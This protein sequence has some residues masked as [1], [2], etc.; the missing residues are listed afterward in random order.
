MMASLS[1]ASY[2]HDETQILDWT[3][4]ACKDSKVSMKPGGIKTV[5]DSRELNATRVLV[6]KLKD[7]S[8]CLLAFRGSATVESWIRDFSIL[9]KSVQEDFEGC[10][11]HRFHGCRVH[12]G[13]LKIWKNVK[14]GVLKALDDV[15]CTPYSGENHLY[16]TGH[17]LGAA[18]AN[19]AAF[20]L[21][22]SGFQIAK[23][24]TFESP[25]IGNKAFADAFD[26][27]FSSRIPVFRITHNADIIVHAPPRLMSYHHVGQEAWY[28]KDGDYRVCKHSEDS[29]CANQFSR[30]F[31][32]PS[33][34]FDHCDSPL[35][36]SGHICDPVG[37]HPQPTRPTSQ[38][39]AIVV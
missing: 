34:I 16:M 1:S 31:P 13:F 11:R 5:V 39:H 29:S 20:D 14:A 6:G 18:L 4:Q 33:D 10:E 32:H 37:C 25:R 12:S 17:S 30:H 28:D 38:P 2:C 23:T 15:G 26:T 35:V 7:T 21:E 3:C 9:K 8:G 24:Y 27:H 22:S 19:L 36:P